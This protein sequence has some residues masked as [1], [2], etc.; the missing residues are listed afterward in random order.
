[1]SEDQLR[2]FLAK[3]QADAYLQDQLKAVTNGDAVVM[4][5]KAAGFSITIEAMDS[6]RRS[7][8]EEEIQDV[9]GDEHSLLIGYGLWL[10][11][12]VDSIGFN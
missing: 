1:M 6:Y 2:A 12:S 8:S 7:V 11:L 9:A 4:I 3:V 5:A 10:V